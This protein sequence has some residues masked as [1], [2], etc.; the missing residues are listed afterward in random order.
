MRVG[1][2]NVLT[3]SEN[4]HLPLLSGELGRLRIAVA[5]LSEVCRPGSSQ[6]SVGEYTYFWSGRSDGRHTKGVAVAVPDWLLP[7]VSDVIPDVN[8]HIMRLRLR[9]SLGVLSVVSVYAPTT[10]SD[11][12]VR[13]AFYS[14]LHSVMDECPGGD[15]PLGDFSAT[16]GTD[17]IGYKDCISPHRSGS[18]GESG[19]VLLER[20]GSASCW[21]LVP[22][23]RAAPLD[24]VFQYWSCG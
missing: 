5:A 21:I 6:I 15:T 11:V 2:W 9:H 22:A 1:M 8:E 17:R 3:L 20:S 14:Q 18:H 12:S 7:M 10:I 19:S 16:T 23:P 13:E 24:L 4:T